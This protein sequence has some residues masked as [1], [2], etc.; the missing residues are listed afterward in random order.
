MSSS[1]LS[2]K[3]IIVAGR[4]R[5]G[6]R[7]D[8]VERELALGEDVQ[9]LAPDIARRADDRDPVTHVHLHS[10]AEGRL[11]HAAR[12]SDMALPF[13]RS[14]GARMSR[15]ASASRCATDRRPPQFAR[16][17]YNR[18]ETITFTPVRL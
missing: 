7:G 2:P 4:A 17:F 11:S 12:E 18:D 9:H 1:P 13:A 6:D 15:A 8:L 10:L 5:G 14:K 16:P 3:S